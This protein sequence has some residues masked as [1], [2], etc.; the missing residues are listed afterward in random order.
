G[1]AKVT[2]VTPAPGGGTSAAL[3]LTVDPPA[4]T[5]SSLAPSSAAV[6]GAAFTLTVSGSSFAASS[7]VQW[8]GA[9][10]ATT[11][12]SSTQL[13]AAIDASDIVAA[14][15][16]QVTVVT[17][18][19]GGGTSAAQIFTINTPTPALS[20][21]A[22]VSGSSFAASSVVQWNGAA[23]ATTF[24]SSTQLQAAIDASDIVAAG[25]AQVTVVTPAP[26]GGTSAAQTFTIGP[27]MA[28]LSVTSSGSG[29][30]TV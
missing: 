28:T 20:S 5:L 13:Q 23:R 6:G 11:F 24:V 19:P 22:P 2:V 7:V 30:G 21:L 9:A 12:V 18:A 8:N 3:T 1:T 29:S 10:R 16:A 17:A 25:T 27:P 15:T 4:P 26:G 14:G